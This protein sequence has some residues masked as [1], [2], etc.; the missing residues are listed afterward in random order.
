MW[1]YDTEP[2]WKDEAAEIFYWTMG[3]WMIRSTWYFLGIP[4]W[5]KEYA[6]S[7]KKERPANPPDLQLRATR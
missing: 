1:R 7:Y 2:Y 3:A 5:T 4:I 6:L